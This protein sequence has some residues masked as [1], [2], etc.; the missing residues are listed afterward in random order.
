[1][2]TVKYAQASLLIMP[3]N[4]FKVFRPTDKE[5][6][7]KGRGSWYNDTPGA[8]FEHV[9]VALSRYCDADKD[10]DYLDLVWHIKNAVIGGVYVSN[11]VYEG[12]VEGNIWNKFV[13]VD[14]G[15]LG[16]KDDKYR[17]H[18]EIIN[19]IVNGTTN[20]QEDEN[21]FD[22][23]YLEIRKWT[24]KDY[25]EGQGLVFEHVI[26]ANIYTEELIRAYNANEFNEDYFREF[27]EKILVCIVTKEEDKRLNEFKS[28]WPGLDNVTDPKEYWSIVTKDILARYREVKVYIHN[29]PK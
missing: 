27:R 10:Y 28:N 29:Y 22:D 16:C 26:P 9:K 11:T 5:Q 12:I 15:E 17:D 3:E 14:N 25:T 20:R 18:F 19:G 2:K 8:R 24:G 6:E 7:R 21:V 23:K 1:M 4:I 13:C